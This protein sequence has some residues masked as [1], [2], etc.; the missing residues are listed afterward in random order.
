MR[1]EEHTP[2]TRALKYDH[3]N[4]HLSWLRIPTYLRRN[5][6]FIGTLEQL[7][8]IDNTLYKSFNDVNTKYIA[9]IN[10][11]DKDGN[12]VGIFGVCWN[13]EISLEEFEVKIEKYLYEDRGILQTYVQPQLINAEIK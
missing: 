6:I 1:F 4:I 12:A 8:D 11:T 7:K 3:S 5:T 13:K 10:L 2:A 9:A